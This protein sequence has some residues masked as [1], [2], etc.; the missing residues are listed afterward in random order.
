[1]CGLPRVPGLGNCLTVSKHCLGAWCL[2][3]SCRGNVKHCLGWPQP[4]PPPPQLELDTAY[5]DIS[6]VALYPR[7]D[8][9]QYLN[10]ARNMTV[11]LSATADFASAPT[12]CAQGL[13]GLVEGFASTVP[14]PAANGIKFVTV[15]RFSNT[16]DSTLMRFD[17]QEIM[18][19]RSKGEPCMH[20]CVRVCV[21]HASASAVQE[22]QGHTEPHVHMV[23]CTAQRHAQLTLPRLHRRGLGHSSHACTPVL[24]VVPDWTH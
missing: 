8:T 17:L 16:T 15:L 1:M 2:L 9:M 19:I 23:R 13:Y 14:C 11:L 5:D 18:V 21:H 3:N 6:Y 24:H 4:P 7:A 10:S 22:A 20:A 12:V